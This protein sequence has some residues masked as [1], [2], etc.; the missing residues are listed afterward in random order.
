MLPVVYEREEPAGR[1]PTTK[2][3]WR[4]AGSGND[5]VTDVNDVVLSPEITTS[6]APT[7]ETASETEK[8]H[9][10]HEPTPL[11]SQVIKIVLPGDPFTAVS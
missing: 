9:S 6:G 5:Q 10:R 4:L 1:P 2:Y 7:H 8:A 3:I 11:R